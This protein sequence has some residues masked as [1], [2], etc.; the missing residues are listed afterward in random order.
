VLR[1]AAPVRVG[2]DLDR[3]E[4]AV[5]SEHGHVADPQAVRQVMQD[6]ELAVF[7]PCLLDS[8]KLGGEP[9]LAGVKCVRR[10]SG[11]P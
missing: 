9:G 2:L 11:G 4:G 5:V 10:A 3:L 8:R 6:R 7:V 1:R